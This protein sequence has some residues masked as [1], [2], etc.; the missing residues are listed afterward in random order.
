[1]STD[2][3]AGEAPAPPRPKLTPADLRSPRWVGA[4]L[5][6]VLLVVLFVLLGRWQ[7][8]AGHRV[9]PLAA[10]Q[11]SAWR[12][13]VPIA[14]VISAET[15]LD[16]SRAGQAVEVT[17]SYDA[18]RQLLVPG[19]ALNGRTGYYVVAPLV[20]GPGKAVVVNRGWLAG[21]APQAA[22]APPAGRLTVVGWAAEPESATGVVSQ[23]GITEPAPTASA[24]GAG[25]VGVISPAQ[26]VNRWPYHLPDAYVSATDPASAAG[27]LTAVPAPLPAHGTTW[28]LLNIGYAFQ[29]CLF[30]VVLVGWYTLHLRRELRPADTGP[31]QP[32][33]E[34]RAAAG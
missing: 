17:G 11:L 13:P 22:P 6:I 8:H 4:H 27:G 16:G 9:E 1:M 28:D 21:A 5:G 32:A 15:G 23:N 33:T 12:R 29:W 25:Q 31:D 19:R 34:E 24:T 20:T 2:D 26:L 10:G 14:D 7:W 18:A 30:A 3:P